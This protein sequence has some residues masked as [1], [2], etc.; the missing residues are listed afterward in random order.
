[1]M[2]PINTYTA[3]WIVDILNDKLSVIYEFIYTY[4]KNPMLPMFN[5]FDCVSS[6]NA[7]S[8]SNVSGTALNIDQFIF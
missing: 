8:N 7:N 2:Q 6:S 5:R 4:S 3:L 1:M